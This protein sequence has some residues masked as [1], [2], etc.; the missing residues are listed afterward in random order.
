[1]HCELS[2]EQLCAFATIR[3]DHI[4]S[5]SLDKPPEDLLTFLAHLQ[6]TLETSY[7]SAAPEPPRTLTSGLI[8][9]IPPG[10]RDSLQQQPSLRPQSLRPSIVPPST[11][12]PMPTAESKD[13]PY[14]RSEG[15]V[16]RN[17]I[18]GL[19]EDDALSLLWSDKEKVWVAVY[20]FV[21]TICACSTTFCV[22]YTHNKIQHI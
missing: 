19:T 7:I 15:V 2:D 6:I 17:I 13:Q 18:W 12:L 11:P 14:V 22:Q 9:T 8:S 5:T 3:V 21:Q 10:R 4:S 16:L 1:M 20:K